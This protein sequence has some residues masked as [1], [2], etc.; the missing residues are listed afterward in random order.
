MRGVIQFD[1][2]LHEY[3]VDGRRLPSVTEILKPL[4]TDLRFV[5]KDLLDYAGSRGTAV[6][7]AVELHVLGTLDYSSLQGEVAD[8]FEQYLAFEA[9]T[10]FQPV[11]SE[12]RVSSKLGYAG[13]LDLGG[14]LNGKFALVDLKTT[15]SLSKA[16]ALQTAAYQK[17]MN[18]TSEYKAESR[19]A[20]RLGRTKYELKAYQNDSQDFA[21]FLGFLT[22]H[23]WCS[24]NG[25][26]ITTEVGKHEF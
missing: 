18:E 17:A 8:Y 9:D 21:S 6:H 22:V 11:I 16:V 14:Y 12:L 26:S 24:A 10:G 3:R 19:F 5:D 15:A 7:K 20:L 23:R 2:A 25:K 4:Y 13:T 1:E